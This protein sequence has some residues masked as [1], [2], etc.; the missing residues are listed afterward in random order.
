MSEMTPHS[1]K[2]SPTGLKLFLLI[3]NNGEQ[4]QHNILEKMS[5][6][7]KM[8]SIAEAA[9]IRYRICKGQDK[10]QRSKN[11][12]RIMTTHI[13]YFILKPV[14]TEKPEMNSACTGLLQGAG[15]SP[16]RNRD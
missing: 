10:G 5:A 6:S 13:P 16:L 12:H 3:K 8:N 1:L 11:D 9:T 7:G 4:Y 14:I 2:G 15:Q